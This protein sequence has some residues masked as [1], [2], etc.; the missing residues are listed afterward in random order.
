[1]T[2]SKICIVS[3]HYPSGV[4]FTTLTKKL[5]TEYCKKHNYDLYYDSETKVPLKVSELHFR[6]CLILIKAKKNF[7]KAEW[8]IW[9]DTDIYPKAINKSIESCIDLSDTSILYHLFHEQP[10]DYPVNT[11]VKIVNQKAIYLEQEIH[12]KRFDCSFPFEQKI[13]AEYILPKYRQHIKIHDPDKLNCIYGLHN[14]DEALFLHVCNKTELERNLIILKNNRSYFQNDEAVLKSKYYK[15]GHFYELLV[16]W[17][18]ANKKFKTFKKLL[19]NGEFKVIL[20]N[21]R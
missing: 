7:P 16:V 3:G 1:M 9:L 10:W 17:H 14:M 4:F 13:M 18:R 6:R 5:L 2:S 20:K 15:Y 11:G 8:F 19:S 12:S 21:L